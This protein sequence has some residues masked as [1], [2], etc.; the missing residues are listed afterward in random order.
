MDQAGTPVKWAVRILKREGL[1]T[2]KPI[3]YSGFM[4]EPN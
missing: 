2:Q 1:K 4:Y 3:I